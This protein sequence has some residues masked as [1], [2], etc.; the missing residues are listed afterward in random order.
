M[1]IFTTFQLDRRLEHTNDLTFTHM[2]PMI[3]CVHVCVRVSVDKFCPVRAF[4]PMK[5]GLCT[6]A[7]LLIGY[8]T[9][10]DEK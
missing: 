6:L 3:C 2:E 9:S 8:C 7:V 10:Q 1:A 5:D 4:N